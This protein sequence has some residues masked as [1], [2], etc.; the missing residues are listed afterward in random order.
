[1]KSTIVPVG[2]TASTVSNFV[3]KGRQEFNDVEELQQAQGSETFDSNWTGLYD[4][5]AQAITPF[6]G[7]GLASLELGLPGYLSN[8]YHR[9]F[10]YFQQ[11]PVNGAREP[12]GV[13]VYGL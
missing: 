1:M 11:S 4:A 12:L 7:T 8:Q 5:P 6:T 13:V 9:G 3:F 10:F 2:S